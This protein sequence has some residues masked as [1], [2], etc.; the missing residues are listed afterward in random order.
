MLTPHDLA[1]AFDRCLSAM[2]QGDNEA[3]MGFISWLEWFRDPMLPLEPDTLPDA[4]SFPISKGE[5]LRWYQGDGAILGYD[6][7]ASCCYR[8][9]VDAE[10]PPPLPYAPYGTEKDHL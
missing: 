7:C 5:G 6:G 1:L 3:A 2:V 10:P 9:P 8:I 4:A